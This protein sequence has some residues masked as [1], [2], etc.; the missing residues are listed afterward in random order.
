MFATHITKIRLKFLYIKSSNKS[1]G[2]RS[3]AQLKKWTKVIYKQITQRKDTVSLED[4]KKGSV[5]EKY[6]LKTYW[7]I[8]FHLSDLQDRSRRH[9]GRLLPSPGAALAA[10]GARGAVALLHNHA[11]VGFHELGHV[12][13]LPGRSGTW[14]QSLPGQWAQPTSRTPCA[15]HGEARACPVSKRR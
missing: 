15:Q 5:S 10:H 13:H 11:D 1:I 3:M 14:S 4:K 9:G 12:H 7:D 6:K 8:F 2:K